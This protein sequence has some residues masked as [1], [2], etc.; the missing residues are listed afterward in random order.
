MAQSYEEMDAIALLK[1]DHRKVEE[2]FAA[3][4]KATTKAKKRA[5]AEQACLELKVHTVLEEE[6]FYPACRGQI[7]GDLLDEGYVEHDTAKLLINE[8]EAASPDDE[9]YDAKVK[10]LS[11]VIEHHVEEEEKRS[12]GMFSQARAAG[13]DMDALADAMRARKVTAMEEFQA[14]K[15]AETLTLEGDDTEKALMDTPMGADAR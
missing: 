1:A 9:F 14:G 3:F 10:V 5:L 7:E 12:E 2:I 8:I 11:E 15:L 4:E 6:I 13:L